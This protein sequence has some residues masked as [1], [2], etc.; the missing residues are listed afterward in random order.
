V[1]RGTDAEHAAHGSALAR[2]VYAFRVSDG[3]Y[4]HISEIPS[5]LDQDLR[6][7][8][9]SC[10]A[11]LVARRGRLKRTPHFAHYGGQAKTCAAG[12]ET[13]AHLLAKDILADALWLELPPVVAELEGETVEVA[14][15]KTLN[16]DRAV[17]EDRL[18]DLIPDVV[19][20]LGH[21]RLLVEVRVTHECDDAKIAKLKREDLPTVEIDIRK[22]QFGD[23]NAIA[24]A[25]LR[26]GPRVWLHNAKQD[27]ASAGLRDRAAKRARE[28]SEAL[29]SRGRTVALIAPNPQSSEEGRAAVARLEALGMADTLLHPLIRGRVFTLPDAEWQ[30]LLAIKVLI[31][32]YADDPFGAFGIAS[33]VQWVRRVG[34]IREGLSPKWEPGLLEAVRAVDPGFQTATASVLRYFKACEGAGILEAA[35]DRRW[36]HT[37]PFRADVHQRLENLRRQSE[38]MASTRTMVG[39]VLALAPD[40]RVGFDFERWSHVIPPFGVSLDTLAQ[41]DD[42]RRLHSGLRGLEWTLRHGAE[43]A[44]ETTHGLP[45]MPAL[46]EAIAAFCKRAEDAETARLAALETSAQARVAAVRQGFLEVLPAKEIEMRLDSRFKG[47]TRTV[48]E[49]AY[50]GDEG[51]DYALSWVRAERARQ[52]TRRRNAD[53]ADTFR[54]QLAAAA[55]K[56][57]GEAHGQLWCSTA[58]G[59]LGGGRPRELCTS[60]RALKRCLA[61]LVD[62]ARGAG[63]RR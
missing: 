15:R 63:R 32:D 16:F 2:L 59:A 34:M 53:I 45:I 51:R 5:G 43:H 19:L 14:P 37:S 58:N 46:D 17:L 52:E 33:P 22:A 40:A 4:V 48:R 61:V 56:R 29:A 8:A 62:Q 6:C 18:G 3:A 24:D 23:R 27:E 28:A 39:D 11:P 47:R 36:R 38:R 50:A 31:A 44:P 30:A 7:P 25:I 57:L 12:R 41:S 1:S 21:R 42:W 13:S 49:E 26:S 20:H 54:K 35:G 9:A 10:R 60:E 55:V